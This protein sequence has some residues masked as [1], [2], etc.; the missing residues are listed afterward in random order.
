LMTINDEYHPI[1]K[2]E[3]LPELIKKLKYIIEN[4]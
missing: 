2:P 3:Q 4:D 1:V